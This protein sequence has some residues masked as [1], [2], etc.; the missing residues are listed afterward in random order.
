VIK[1]HFRFNQYYSSISG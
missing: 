1:A